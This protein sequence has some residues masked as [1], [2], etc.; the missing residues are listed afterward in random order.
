MFW[1]SKAADPDVRNWDLSSA[2]VI[3]QMFKNSKANPDVSQWDTSGVENMF[4]LFRGASRAD[5]DMS[6]WD[7]SSVTSVKDMFYGVTISTYNY[8]TYLIRLDA[9]APN[10]LTAN[11]GGSTYTSSGAGGSARASL[12]GK[13][14]TISDGG[15]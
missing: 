1:G 4:E 6:N 3:N 2:T 5:P 8:D 7:F 9:T 15:T 11:G 10:G 13:G 14:W 12:I